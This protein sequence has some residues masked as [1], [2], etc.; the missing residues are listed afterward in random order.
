MQESGTIVK[1]ENGR[2][3]IQMDG[4]DGAGCAS[5]GA[6]HA[7]SPG[8]GARFVELPSIIDLQPGS[9]VRLE[10]SEGRSIGLAFLLFI[11]PLLVIIG[12]YL[13][14]DHLG[15]REVSAI[16]ASLG[17]GV[18][19]FLLVL[20]LEDRLLSQARVTPHSHEREVII[21]PLDRG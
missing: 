19:V 4:P 13:L 20:K 14:Y 17:S 11:L 8:K 12:G 10:I 18:A 3:V 5:C 15:W 1:N 7:C 2:V 6:R 16:A 21:H 9:R